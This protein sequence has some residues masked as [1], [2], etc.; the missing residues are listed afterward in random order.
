MRYVMIAAAA[1]ILMT[2]CGNAVRTDA[3]SKKQDCESCIKTLSVVTYHLND[4]TYWTEQHQRFCPAA[5]VFDAWGT[6]PEGSWH[7]TFDKSDFSAVGIKGA[8]MKSLPGGLMDAVLAELIYYSF[9]AG[10]GF[11]PTTRAPEPISLQGRRYESLQVDKIN[12]RHAITLYRDLTT[13]RIDWVRIT[14]AEQQE[15]MAQSYNFRY[16]ARLDRMIPRKI[17]VFDVHRGIA[18]KKRLVEF[19]YIEVQ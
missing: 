4:S 6:E 7:G 8:F 14:T 1:A 18:A 12:S 9:T 19:D 10:A 5:V 17:D 13:G 11:K 15:W 3:E 2:G 16:N